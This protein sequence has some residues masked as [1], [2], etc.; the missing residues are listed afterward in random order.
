MWINEP[1]KLWVSPKPA[2]IRQAPDL[3]VPAT[4]FLVGVPHFKAA[5]AGGTPISVAFTDSA[6]DATN[7]TS[8]SFATRA[9]GTADATRRVFVAVNTCNVTGTEVTITGVTLGGNAMTPIGTPTTGTTDRWRS[10]L[11]YRDEASG[12]TATIAV[13]LTGNNPLNCGIGVW[14]VYNHASTIVSTVNISS[15]SGTTFDYAFGGSVSNNDV[16]ITSNYVDASTA[17]TN[18]WST[19]VGT[20]NVVESFDATVETVRSHSGAAGQATASGSTTIRTTISGTFGASGGM[21]GSGVAVR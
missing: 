16:I 15:S 10:A 8:Y 18:V 2:I 4:T 9:I 19:T 17:R 1:P 14:A 5:T 6:V 12:T 13:T 7:G 3:L 11:F 21:S 20:S